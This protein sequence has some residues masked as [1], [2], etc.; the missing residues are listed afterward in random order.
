MASFLQQRYNS[1]MPTENVNLS[2]QQVR[3][4]RQRVDEGRY[5]NVSEVVG[6]ALQL[7]ERQEQQEELKLQILRRLA[8]ESFEELDR[9][10]YIAVESEGIDQFVEELAA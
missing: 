5:G 1:D 4:I 9:D 10:E 2:E 3:F 7:L 8:K 6:A